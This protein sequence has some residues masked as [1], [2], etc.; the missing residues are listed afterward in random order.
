MISLY[1]DTVYTNDWITNGLLV[2]QVSVVK[3]MDP[4]REEFLSVVDSKRG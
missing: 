4:K 3:F 1:W 2:G